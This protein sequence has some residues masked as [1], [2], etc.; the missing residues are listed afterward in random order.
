[1][2]YK[3]KTNMSCGG[4]LQTVSEELKKING[5]N[6]WHA[7]LYHPNKIL[8]IDVNNVEANLIIDSVKKVGYNL[9]LI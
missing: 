8:T 4:C 6:N 1:M 5:I 7:D 2:I 3:F 9:Q